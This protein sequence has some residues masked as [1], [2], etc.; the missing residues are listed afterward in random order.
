VFAVRLETV[1]GLLAPVAECVPLDVQIAWYP[2]I[3]APPVQAGAENDTEIAEQL[4]AVAEPIVG[5]PG[6]IAT[7]VD[8]VLELAE[9]FPALFVAV[10]FAY[11]VLPTSAVTSV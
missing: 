9:A 8:V 5:A 4:N 6:A 1:I 10:T 3:E 2:V 11:S 7:T